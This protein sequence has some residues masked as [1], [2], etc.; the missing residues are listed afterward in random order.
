MR[1]R[2]E[3]NT[4]VMMRIIP[5][6]TLVIDDDDAVCRKVA[7]WLREAACDVVTFTSPAQGLEHAARAPCQIGLVDLRL[8]G[9]DGVEVVARLRA[10]APEM[11]VIAM[12]AFPDA[13]QVVAAMRAGARDLL[14]KP[15]QRKPLLD[16]LEQQLAEVGVSVRSEKEF[17]QR[18]GARIR[19]VRMQAERTLA[20]IAGECGLTVAQLSQIEL[21]KSATSTWGLARIG[22]AL[23]TPLE[24]LLADPRWRFGL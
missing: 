21:G 7:A 16:A 6:R 24:K 9:A 1:A 17:N 4:R 2:I 15:I 11:R 19:A 10:A 8:A 18:L 22:S 12:S 23:K 3:E 13:R 5:V 14:E 20:D